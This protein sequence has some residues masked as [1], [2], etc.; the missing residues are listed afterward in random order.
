MSPSLEFRHLPSW[1]QDDAA[2]ALIS[3]IQQILGHATLADAA[4]TDAPA[5]ML[6]LPSSLAAMLARGLVSFTR[7]RR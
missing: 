6:P 1:A 4:R 5:M 3:H 7:R 2:T